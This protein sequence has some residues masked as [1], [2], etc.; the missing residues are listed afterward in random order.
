MTGGAGNDIFRFAAASHSVVGVNADVITDF[1]DF[2]DDRI[3]LGAFAGTL[4]YKGT[5][6]INGIGQVNIAASGAD[7]LVHVNLGGTFAS[8][9]DIRL[10]N[11]TLASMAASDFFL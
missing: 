7:V 3:D 8:D 5:A 1:D 2:G 11:T 6:A 10:A 4:I 9:M